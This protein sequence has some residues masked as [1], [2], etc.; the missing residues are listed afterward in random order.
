[1]NGVLVFTDRGYVTDRS[2]TDRI[3]LQLDQQYTRPILANRLAGKSVSENTNSVSSGAL[4]FNSIS[5]ARSAAA[6]DK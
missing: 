2:E 1:M 6:T 4:N 3:R 5:Q